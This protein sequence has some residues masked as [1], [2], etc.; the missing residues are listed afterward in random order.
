MGHI[1][2]RTSSLRPT[3][4]SS[5]PEI[6]VEFAKTCDCRGGTL[7]SSTNMSVEG[8]PNRTFPSSPEWV[9][10]D[11]VGRRCFKD[12]RQLEVEQHYFCRQGLRSVDAKWMW[13]GDILYTRWSYSCFMAP[14]FRKVAQFP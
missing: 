1:F 6:T 7:S 5:I 2:N 13:V 3:R 8:G 12:Q 10:G 9:R 4:Q 11:H 14:I